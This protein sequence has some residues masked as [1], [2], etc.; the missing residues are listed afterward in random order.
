MEELF[1]EENL[2]ARQRNRRK[3]KAKLE[4]SC[5]GRPGG[6]NGSLAKLE[7][8]SDID[9]ATGLEVKPNNTLLFATEI[10]LDCRWEVGHRFM[11]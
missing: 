6:E 2:S 11:T 8:K 3:H 5:L 9:A 4:A 7:I 10:P 1:E